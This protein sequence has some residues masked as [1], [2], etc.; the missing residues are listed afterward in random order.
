[1]TT[2]HL[3]FTLLLI[4]GLA[5]ATQHPAQDFGQKP[6]SG[7]DM[8]LD[9]KEGDRKNNEDAFRIQEGDSSVPASRSYAIGE[10]PANAQINQ[11]QL[12][13]IEHL[14]RPNNGAAYYMQR[15]EAMIAN[16]KELMGLKGVKDELQPETRAKDAEEDKS[17][18]NAPPTLYSIFDAQA[19]LQRK[20]YFIA[21][22]PSESRLQDLFAKKHIVTALF[23]AIDQGDIAAVRKLIC[24]VHNTHFSRQLFGSNSEWKNGDITSRDKRQI[25][26]NLSHDI[27]NAGKDSQLPRLVKPNIETFC[28]QLREKNGFTALM[29]ASMRGDKDMVAMLLKA[30]PESITDSTMLSP[31]MVDQTAKINYRNIAMQFAKDCWRVGAGRAN[32]ADPMTTISDLSTI[33]YD[34]YYPF[35]LELNALALASLGGHSDVFDLLLE[36]LLNVNAPDYAVAS[37]Y[38]V[39]RQAMVN[40]LQVLSCFSNVADTKEGKRLFKELGIISHTT[41][42]YPFIARKLIKAIIKAKPCDDIL[43]RLDKKPEIDT[44]NFKKT[45]ALANSI[46]LHGSIEMMESIASELAYIKSQGSWVPDD[47]RR[48]HAADTLNE[49][50]VA[51]GINGEKLGLLLSMKP[52][53]ESFVHELGMGMLSHLET[54]LRNPKLL[55]SLKSYVE[56][57]QIPYGANRG[58]I[59]R[60]LTSYLPPVLTSIVADY[61]LY[62]MPAEYVRY[63]MALGNR[64]DDNQNLLGEDMQGIMVGDHPIVDTTRTNSSRRSMCSWLMHKMFEACRRRNL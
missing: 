36:E 50:L 56:R 28:Q 62:E 16:A 61:S 33:F 55:T 27:A 2:K 60:E 54:D 52:Y 3:F 15:A 35:S 32:K 49:W 9:A 40:A 37:Y 63:I 22:N 8:E 51:E 42:D 18:S 30:Q 19:K 20:L 5:F 11:T 25:F 6:N 39:R 7:S 45:K 34:Y 23:E 24:K 31:W 17:S 4:P 59:D 43:R 64:A 53:P 29:R 41:K 57:T 58:F 13:E 48:V 38:D 26:L 46:M 1:M 44:Y 21:Q 10:S 14:I 47:G 12:T